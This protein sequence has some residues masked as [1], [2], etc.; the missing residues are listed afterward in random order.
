MG[1]IIVHDYNKDTFYLF[2]YLHSSK[3]GERKK[4]LTPLITY[5]E[6]AKTGADIEVAVNR[7]LAPLKR[8]AFSSTSSSS[9]NGQKVNGSAS[10]P[11]EESTSDS[12]MEDNKDFDEKCNGELSY[13]L[14]ISDER[15]MSG[16]P[17]LKDTVIKPNKM[18]KVLLDWTEKEH[19]LYDANYLKDLPTVNKPGVSVKKTK[20]ESISL[21][22]CLDAFLKEEPLGP[23]DMWYE[24]WIIVIY[25]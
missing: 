2:I 11:M 16:R 4:F 15:G 18:V 20:Q 22:S 23:D 13:L 7:V 12:L 24:L 14:C 8:K 5:L 3:A 19:D 25:F 21:F 9:S 1:I 17:L 6:G 10:E